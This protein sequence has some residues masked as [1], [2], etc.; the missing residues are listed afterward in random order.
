MPGGTSTLAVSL[1]VFVAGFAAS[2]AASLSAS[3]SEGGVRSC[4]GCSCCW[5]CCAGCDG[6]GFCCVCAESRV[7]QIKQNK[8]T[9]NKFLLLGCIV[10]RFSVDIE[11]RQAFGGVEL[12]PQF[13]PFA[14]PR[15]VSWTVSEHILV[16]QLYSNLC[17]YVCQ[18]A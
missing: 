12:D 6:A 7:P 10:S 4:T 14:V 11:R 9:S 17:S 5:F 16:A 13:A 2:A 8:A 15:L 18:L 1:P 3:A